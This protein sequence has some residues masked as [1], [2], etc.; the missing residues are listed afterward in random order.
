MF[1]TR[2]TEYHGKGPSLRNSGWNSGFRRIPEQINLALEWFNSDVCSAEFR[3]FRGKKRIPENKARQEPEYKTECTSKVQG[4]TGN[5][6]TPLLGNYSL[7]VAPAAA[8]ATA[9]KTTM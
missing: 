4:Y 3:G 6:W 5:H 8:R 1:A 7:R 2:G 9:N